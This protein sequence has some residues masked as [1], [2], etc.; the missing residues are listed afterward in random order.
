MQAT[1]KK[2]ANPWAL[3][4][5]QD[6]QEGVE[7]LDDEGGFLGVCVRSGWTQIFTDEE[8]KE[9]F[10][11]EDFTVL[12]KR[13]YMSA[14]PPPEWHPNQLPVQ[15]TTT[16]PIATGGG[17]WKCGFVFEDGS[18]C[19]ACFNTYKGVTQRDVTWTA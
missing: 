17:G 15:T 10:L 8:V 19:S 9:E 7:G 6:V 4:V 14:V 12:R 11:N 3:Q 13:V 2:D 1:E 5:R 16:V 18:V